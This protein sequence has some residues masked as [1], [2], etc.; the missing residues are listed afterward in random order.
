VPQST[1][2]AAGALEVT[3]R[4]ARRADES[5]R[6]RTAG[7]CP[8]RAGSQFNTIE[9]KTKAGNAPIPRES[10]AIA[11]RFASRTP[12]R[13]WRGPHGLRSRHSKCAVARAAP[14]RPSPKDRDEPRRPFAGAGPAPP[15]N[16]HG[17]RKTSGK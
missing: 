11:Q 4:L 6:P 17:R 2:I 14:W 13:A 9:R 8:D 3:I 5:A 1:Q 10:T 15:D 7:S 12:D 16:F